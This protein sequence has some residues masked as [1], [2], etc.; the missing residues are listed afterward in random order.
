MKVKWQMITESWQ[1]FNWTVKRL[2]WLSGQVLHWSLSREKNSPFFIKSCHPLLLLVLLPCIECIWWVQ[3]FFIPLLA[4]SEVGTMLHWAILFHNFGSS[5]WKKSLGLENSLKGFT[6]DP[7]ALAAFFCFLGEMYVNPLLSRSLGFFL[8]AY[9]NVAASLWVSPGMFK[10]FF[11]QTVHNTSSGSW[12]N[13]TSNNR[14]A[15]VLAEVMLS[16]SSSGPKLSIH[17]FF[18]MPRLSF[19]VVKLISFSVLGFSVVFCPCLVLEL[20]GPSALLAACCA[21]LRDLK[22]H[23]DPQRF[24]VWFSHAPRCPNQHETLLPLSLLPL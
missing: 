10:C 19:S 4:E 24:I 5:Y 14:A 17:G 11:F 13:K 1:L 12:W 6:W 22:A 8:H 21:F 3:L 7:P 18:L 2:F 15:A 9:L 16:S 23:T 20:P